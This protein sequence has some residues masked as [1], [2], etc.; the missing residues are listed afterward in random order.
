[1]QKILDD[2][3]ARGIIR[4]SD[5]PYASPIVLT[6]KKNKEI[7][8]CV[9]Y[10]FINKITL[11]ENYPL[12]LIEDLLDRLRGKRYFTSLDLK[13][14]FH[15]VNMARDSVKY[16][17]F[18]TPLGHYEYL[19]M[20][21]GLKTAPDTFQKFINKIF[22]ELIKSGDVVTYLD[23]VLIATDNIE[24]HLE[25]LKKCFSLMVQNKLEHHLDKCKFLEK[26]T[27]YL[28]YKISDSGISPTNRGVEA[29]CNFPVPQNI[30]ELQSFLGLCAY[31][32]KFVP[33]FSLTAKPLYDLL[34][35]NVEFLFCEKQ[36]DAFEVLKKNL[37][38]SPVLSIYDPRDE[39]E[40]HCD[41][42]KLGFGAVLL[43]RKR[44]NHFHPIAYFSKR[45][46]EVESRYHSFELETLAIIYALRRFRIY[47]QGIVFKI[48]TDC[49]ALKL[50][51][52]KKEIN[53]RICRWSAELE[54]YDKTLEHRNGEKMKHVDA[55]SR[56]T[57][58]MI[59]EDNTLESNLAISQNLDD[60]IKELRVKLENSED[61]FFEMRNGL[62]YRKKITKFCFMYRGKWKII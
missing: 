3:L 23:D 58:I 11:R 20:P 37:M 42:S 57:N 44:D 36:Y 54:N 48:V 14:G 52:D 12:P 53:P 26:E 21:F 13:D 60:K 56:A 43:Q 45:T 40:L 4:E 35:K 30:R 47:L 7:R 59:I 24:R 18:I 46:T 8:L 51:L 6:K 17:A 16:T 41:A 10:R 61:K 1:M 55:F 27:E 29:V 5:S 2:L 9:D 25:V 22:T 39:T 28:G 32:R 49:N 50:T 38:E 33:G 62:V 19:K 15:H 34:R 31:F